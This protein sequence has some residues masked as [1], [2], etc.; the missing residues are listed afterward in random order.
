MR[1]TIVALTERYWRR[2]VAVALALGAATLVVFS[3]QV[4][5]IEARIGA[6]LAQVVTGHPA[7]AIPGADFFYVLE[8]TS[9]TFGLTVTAE[10]TSSYLVAPVLFI[11]GLMALGRRVSLNR[12]LIGVGLAASVLFAL[13]LFRITMIAW[14]TAD[15]GSNG[16]TW[17]HEVLGSGITVVAYVLALTLLIA[18]ARK[19]KPPVEVA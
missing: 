5:E 8:Q 9:R 17:S 13:N 7:S 4:R 14:A 6:F 1:T 3:F 11:G 18:V 16:F 2:M 19:S 12:V 10:C 15:Y